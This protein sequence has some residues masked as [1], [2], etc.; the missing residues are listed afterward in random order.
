MPITLKVAILPCS[1]AA[2]HSHLFLKISPEKSGVRVFL[3][4]K[5]QT[6]GSE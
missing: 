3:L 6:D 5:L 2:V 1:E 4:V